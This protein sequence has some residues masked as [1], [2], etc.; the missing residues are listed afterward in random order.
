L[1]P[2]KCLD[3]TQVPLYYSINDKEKKVKIYTSTKKIPVLAEKPLTERMALLE[4]AAK[5]MSVPEKTLLNML[6]LLVL[7]PAF[8]L[9]LQVTDNWFSLAWAGLI[10]LLYPILVKPIQYSLCAKYLK[11]NN[12]K[13]SD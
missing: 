7:V 9:I 12:V 10:L 13:D 1:Y 8:A 4:E 2:N 3:K 11:A 6:K 5:K